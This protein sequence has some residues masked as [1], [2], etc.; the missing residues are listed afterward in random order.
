MTEESKKNGYVR[1]PWF[2]GFCL[3]VAGICMSVYIGLSIT[4]VSKDQF[5]AFEK[6]LDKQLEMMVNNL[7]RIE[8]SL[9]EKVE[10]LGM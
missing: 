6:G 9:S 10:A 4:M 7:S 1:W 5:G 3:T 2:A 8:E